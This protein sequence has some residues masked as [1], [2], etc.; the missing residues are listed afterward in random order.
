LAQ[1]SPPPTITWHILSDGSQGA[2]DVPISH[3]SQP[4]NPSSDLWT[5]F[6]HNNSIWFRPFSPNEFKSDV[7]QATYMCRAAS[8]SGVIHS[9]SIKIKAGKWK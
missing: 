1:G 7:H 9:K 4:L 5:I 3:W 6:P 2:A 8:E